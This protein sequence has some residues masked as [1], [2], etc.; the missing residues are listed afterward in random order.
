VPSVVKLIQIRFPSLV[1]YLTPIAS[2]EE[3]SARYIKEKLISDGYREDEIGIFLITPCTAKT[4]DIKRKGF[5]LY[6]WNYICC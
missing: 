3:I 5:S 6:K 2:P 4:A 1:E